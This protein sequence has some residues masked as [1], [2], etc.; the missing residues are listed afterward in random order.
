VADLQL[1][2]VMRQPRNRLFE[3]SLPAHACRFPS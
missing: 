1:R 3:E 2:P